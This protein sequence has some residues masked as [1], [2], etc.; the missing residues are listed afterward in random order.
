MSDRHEGPL[1]SGE[2]VEM[3]ARLIEPDVRAPIAVAINATS[4]GSIAARAFVAAAKGLA[5]NNFFDRAL[6]GHR[7]EVDW[8]RLS[9]GQR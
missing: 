1:S 7:A 5:L 8:S 3:V 4:P 9:T 6:V 2:A